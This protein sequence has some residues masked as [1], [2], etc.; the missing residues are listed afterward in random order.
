MTREAIMQRMLEAIDRLDDEKV[1]RVADFAELLARLHE[2]SALVEGIQKLAADSK[3]FEFLNNE[4][5][6]YSLK[7]LKA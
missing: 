5:E 6:L 2:E 7:D 1:A 3:V 4:E